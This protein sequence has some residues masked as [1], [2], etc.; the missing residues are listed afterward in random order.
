[1]SAALLADLTSRDPQRV[2][3]AMWAVVRL[4][5]PAGLDALAVALPEIEQATAGLEL[6]GMVHSNADTLAFALRKLR[7]HR[8]RLG[9]LCALYPEHLLFDPEKEAAAGHVR[10]LETRYVQDRWLDAFRCRCTACGA[11]FHVQYGEGH[12][13]W[14]QWTAEA[15]QAPA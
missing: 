12:A 8:D 5:D 15:R 7:H 1:M 10:I 13:S 3:G 11:T 6:G 2:I 4:R 9:C 14:W